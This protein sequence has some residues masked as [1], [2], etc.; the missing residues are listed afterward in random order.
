[1][2]SEPF[3]LKD[4]AR[5]QY[6]ARWEA[7]EIVKAQE[8]AAMTDERAWQIIERLGAVEGW[9]ERTDWSGLVE[10]QAL[11]HKGRTS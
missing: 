7:V 1:M 6:H 8:L 11:F 10:Q 4:A 2:K 5:A 9:R 3:E